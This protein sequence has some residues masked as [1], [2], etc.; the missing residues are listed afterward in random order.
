MIEPTYLRSNSPSAVRKTVHSSIGQKMRILIAE[1][2]LQTGD[3]H[4]PTYIGGLAHGFREAGD[5]VDVLAHRDASLSV[6]TS[7]GGT[8]W[9]SRNCWLDSRSHGAVGGV[10]HNLSFRAEL[11]YWLKNHAPYDWVCALTMRL[12]HLLAFALLSRDPQIPGTTRFLLLF[13]QGFGRYD[14]VGKPTVF[15]N[16]P[17]TWLAR[18]CFRALAP[19]VR[20]GRVVL[21]AETEGMQEELHRFTGLPVALF[22][23]PVLPVKIIPGSKF[24]KFGR[25]TITCPGFARHEKGSDHLQTAIKRLLDDPVGDGL[26]FVLQWPEPFPMPDGTSRGVDPELA[27]DPRIEWLNS[28][29]EADAYE[30]LLARSDLVILPYRRE[31]YHHRVSRVAIEAA[32]RGIPLIFTEGTWSE[33]I[34]EIAG[35]GV[36]IADETVAAI[37]IAVLDAVDRLA[38][39]R[40]AAASGAV[41]VGEYHSSD[42]FRD[43][44][45]RRG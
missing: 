30:A 12:Q 9:F 17:S 18:F 45:T 3:G 31:S 19:A 14:G 22:P 44:M 7:C 11:T 5:Q 27:D 10:R 25:V 16:S 28:S 29:L 32:S 34:A 37:T 15:P 21:A 33:R 2:A 23:H 24:E 1:E 35:V 36:P 4:W 41:K 43:L 20:N 40:V 13:V 42:R 8:P 38:S 39:L 6:I 26:H